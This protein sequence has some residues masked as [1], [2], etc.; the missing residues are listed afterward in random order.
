MNDTVREYLSYGKFIIP[1][2]KAKK[3][4]TPEEVRWGEHK[5]Q[6]F[7]YFPAREPRKD[8]VVIY[9]HGGGWN[10]HE[11]RQDFYIGQNIASEGYDCFMPGYRKTPKYTY[12]AITDDIFRDYKEIKSFMKAR[13]LSFGKEV[14]MGSSA[15]AHLGAVLCFNREL[16]KKHGIDG[17][18]F[19]GLL[20]MAGPLYFGLPQTGTLDTLLRYLF[21]TKE[22]IEWLRGEPYSMVTPKEDFKIFMIQ[23]KHDGLVGWEQA[24]VFR[25]KASEN[26]IPCELYEV[27]ESWNTH[28]AYCAGVFLKNRNESDTLETAYGMLD[29]V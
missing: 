5:D 19:S 13:G 20:T 26:G 23:S 3:T 24:E 11:P 22:K 15:G 2:M 28:S 9:I 14:I 10:S 29:R 21:G 17:N 12:D 4:I 7:H 25:D 16:Q 6:Y 8:K 1:L 27:K 18:D